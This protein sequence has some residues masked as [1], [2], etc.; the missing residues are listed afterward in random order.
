[1]LWIAFVLV[2]ARPDKSISLYK[3][4]SKRIVLLEE[5]LSRPDGFKSEIQPSLSEETDSRF[6]AEEMAKFMADTRRV[7]AEI[8][9]TRLHARQRRIQENL[10]SAGALALG[11]IFLLLL[12]GFLVRW[13]IAGFNKTS[14]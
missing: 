3:E 8:E 14:A 6:S 9:L 2:G 1:M 13:I 12:L 10:I 7:E 11:P 4:S 5:K